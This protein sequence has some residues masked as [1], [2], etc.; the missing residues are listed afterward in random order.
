MTPEPPISDPQRREHPDPHEGTTPVPKALLMAVALLV[1]FCI[2]Y[3]AASDIETPAAWGDGRHAAD[4][5]GVSAT[6]AGTVDGAAV[7]ASRCAACHQAQGQGLPGVFPPLAG[8]EWV[9]GKDSTTAAIVLHGV[10]G[11]LSVMG[12]TYNGAMPAF[13]E[14]L[15][16]AEIAAVLTH[17]RTHWGN[18]AAAVTAETVALARAAHRGRTAPFGSQDLPPLE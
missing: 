13:G 9:K 7:F 6:I 15:S 17:V 5:G 10:T 3:I 18:Q 4:L 11:P 16:D 14:L 12:Q 2:A 1:A 8:S